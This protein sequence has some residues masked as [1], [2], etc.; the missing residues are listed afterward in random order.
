M[1]TVPDGDHLTLLNAYN[2]YIQSVS[3]NFLDPTVIDML[4]RPTRQELVL[5]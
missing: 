4:R 5:G 2:A 3:T 1:L